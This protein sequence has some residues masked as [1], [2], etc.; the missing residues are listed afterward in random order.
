MTTSRLP[1]RR[2]DGSAVIDGWVAV[3]TLGLPG[4]IGPK[5]AAARL[6]AEARR[7]FDHQVGF[8]DGPFETW[9]W[10]RLPR[11]GPKSIS[12]DTPTFGAS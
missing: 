11:R 1:G 7:Y 5:D 3:Y 6:A 10:R 2:G 4:P 12:P 8:P 9:A